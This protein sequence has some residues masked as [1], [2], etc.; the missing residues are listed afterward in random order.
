M[1]VDALL[2]KVSALKDVRGAGDEAGGIEEHVHE[3]CEGG[4]QRQEEE[5]WTDNT[6]STLDQIERELMAL[7]ANKG[8]KGGKGGKGRKGVPRKLQLLWKIRPPLERV[9]GKGSRHESQRRRTLDPKG[10]RKGGRKDRDPTLTGNSSTLDR[11]GVAVQD[12]K[13]REE[14]NG[15]FGKEE[16]EKGTQARVERIGLMESL[17]KVST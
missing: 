6:S 3:S 8:G 1:E 15:V 11:G 7:E 4:S 9:L 2:A 10:R 12:G 17:R 13:Q 14:Q 5:A 16:K